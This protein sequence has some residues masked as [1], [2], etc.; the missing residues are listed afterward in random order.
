MLESVMIFVITQ[1]PVI[2][3][4]LVIGCQMFMVKGHGDN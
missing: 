2:G 1:Q 3:L 4:S